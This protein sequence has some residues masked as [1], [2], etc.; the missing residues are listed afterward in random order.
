MRCPFLISGS[1]EC[2]SPPLVL[3]CIWHDSKHGALIVIYG[4]NF[5]ALIFQAVSF[6][7]SLYIKVSIFVIYVH[8]AFIDYCDGLVSYILLCHAF[9]HTLLVAYQIT[10]PKRILMQN[11]IRTYWKLS[12]FSEMCGTMQWKL[13]YVKCAYWTLSFLN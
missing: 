13:S 8:V 9:C 5:W 3:V 7:K 1:T 2:M 4:P 10:K 12:W 11:W 6:L